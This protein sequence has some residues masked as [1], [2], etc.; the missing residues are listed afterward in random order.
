V[1]AAYLMH[2][3]GLGPEEAIAVVMARRDVNVAPA[4]IDLLHALE[5]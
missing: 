5:R 1:V 3:R 4:L 2:D